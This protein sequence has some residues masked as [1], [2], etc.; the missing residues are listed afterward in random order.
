MPEELTYKLARCCSPQPDDD[1]IGYFKEDGTIALH[2]SDCRAVKTLRSER[3]LTVTWAELATKETPPGENDAADEAFG[4]LDETDYRILKHHEQLGL[5]YS[6]M[7]ADELGLEMAVAYERHRKLRSLGALERVEKRMIQYR[8]HI[9]KGK[10]I[11]HRNHTYYDL[12]AKGRKW[13]KRFEE[14]KLSP[15]A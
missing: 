6:M 4:Q 12:T 13:I 9:V 5:D 2:R 1:I 3:L 10:W 15:K 11:K 7:V 8:K 14:R